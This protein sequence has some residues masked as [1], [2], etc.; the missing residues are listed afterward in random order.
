MESNDNRIFLNKLYLDPIE[1]INTTKL[2]PKGYKIKGDNSKQEEKIEIMR[3]LPNL[4]TNQSLTQLPQ[5]QRQ[6]NQLMGSVIVQNWETA[7]NIPED[8]G[9]LI[10]FPVLIDRKKYRYKDVDTEEDQFN[11]PEDRKS[12]FSKLAIKNKGEMLLKPNKQLEHIT[13]TSQNYV[14]SQSTA[15][16][17]LTS[18]QTEG[19]QIRA[20]ASQ[21]NAIRLRSKEGQEK[22]ALSLAIT[23]PPINLKS[24]KKLKLIDFTTFNKHLYLRDN[25][26]LYAKRV[27]GPVDFVLCTYQD[28]NPK[29][30]VSNHMSQSISGKKYLAPIGKKKKVIDYITISKNTVIHYQK[31]IPSVYSIQEWIDNYDKYKQLMKI[32][33]FKNFRNAKLFDLWR[34]FYKKTKRQYYTEKLKKKFFFID[35]H[36]LQGILETRNLLKGMKVVNIFD[37]QQSS[38]LLLNQFNELH[39]LNLVAIDKKI[40]LFRNKVKRILDTSCKESYKEYKTQKKITLDDDNNVGGGGNDKD[41]NKKDQPSNNIQNFIKDSIPYAQDATRKTHYKKLL[42]YI[43]VMDYVFNETK[44]D[45]INYSLEQLDKKFKRLYECYVNKW[46]DPPMLVTKIL[47]MGDKIYYNPS[48]RLMSES[49]FDN[50]IQETIYC[51][52][53]KKNFIDPQEFPR[54][55]S[56]FEEVFEIS[57]DQNSN[58]NNRIKETE[59]ITDKFESIKKNF[60]LCHVELNK[61]VEVL[62]PILDNYLKNSKINFKELEQTATP[63]QLKELLA[64]FHE[65]EKVIKQLKPVKAVGIFEFQLDDLLELV[66]DAPK[67]W[68]EKIR[69]VIPNVLITKVKKTIERLS[70]HLTDLSVNP[71]DIES[72]IKLKKAVE[73]CNKEKQL[74]EEVTNDIIDLQNIID[75]GKEIK[76]NDYDNK[77][78]IEL[79]DLNV[80]YDR[81]LDSTSYFI[82]NNIQQ[83]RLDLKNEIAKFD[84]QIKSMMSELNNDTL[85]TYNEDTFNALDFLEENSLKIKK[86]LVMKDKYQQQ[87]ED[88]ELDETLKSNFENLDNLV[89]EQELKVNLWNSVKEF[90]DQSTHWDSEQ[91]LQIN[92]E[93]MKNSI[94]H[95][96]DLCQVAL[97]DLDIPQVPMELKKKVEVYEQIVPILEAIQNV[98]IR[99]V[100]H[101]LTLLSELLRTE[102]KL[103]DPGFTCDRIKHL[104]EIFTRIPDIQELNNRANEE[105]RLKDIV[106]QTSDSF[107]NRKIPTKLTKKEIDKEFEF[108][109]ENLRMLNKIYLNKYFLFI[110]KDLDK[111]TDDLMKYQKF[112]THYVYFQ[113]YV[114]KSEAILEFNEFAKENPAEH[115]RLMSENLKKNFYKN[116]ADYRVIQKF[117]DHVYEKQIGLINSIIQSY[118]QNYKAIFNFFNKKRLETPRF[119]LLSNDDINNIFKE[120]ESNEIKQKMLYKIYR[121]I[122]YVNVDENPENTISLTTTDNEEFKVVLTK[123]SRTLQDLIEFLDVFLIKKLKDNF[124]TFKREYESSLK[125]KNPDDKK[126][127]DVIKDLITNKENLAQGIF[128]CIY[129]LTIDSIEKSLFVADEAFDKLFDLY[130]EIKDEK[131]VFFM[132]LI[133]EKDTTKVQK[134]VLFNLI[135]L[136]N[137]SKVIIENLIR[138]DVTTNN[139]FTF[140]K[141]INP[142]IENDSFTLHFIQNTFEYGF[143]YVGL[144]DNFLIMPE[145]ER[146]YIA[147]ANCIINQRPFTMYG[148]QD[149]GKKEILKI[150]ANLCGKK[151]NYINTTKNFSFTSF[152]NFF[153]G[154]IKQGC[155]LCIDETQNIKYEILETLALRIAEFYRILQSG[156]EF[157]LENGDKVTANVNQFSIFFYRELPYL[158]PFSDKSIPKVIKNYYRHMSMPKFDYYFYLNQSL[159]NLSIEKNEERTN[160][161]FY[162]LKYLQSKV[163][164]FKNTSLKMYFISKIIDDLNNK[165]S[166]LKENNAN[167][168]LY[169]RNLLMSLLEDIIDQKEKE[170]YRKFLNEVFLM[171]DYEEETKNYNDDP[172][173]NDCI[174]KVLSSMKINSQNYEKQI[175]FLYTSLL[176]FNSFILVGPP[177]SGKTNLIGLVVNISKQLFDIDKT[178][179]NKILNVKIY[180]KSQTSDDLFSENKVE[181]AY[182]PNNNFFYNMLSLFDSENEDMLM[183]LNEHYTKLLGFQ[184]PEVDEE[185]TPEK[186]KSLNEKEEDNDEDNIAILNQK[187]EEDNTTRT[188][189]MIILDGQIDDSWIEY[190]NNLYD[191]DNFLSLANGDVLN[192]NEGYKFV[193]ETASLRYAHPSFLTKQIIIPCSYETYG[194]ETILYTWI[195]SNPKVTENSVLKNYIRGLFENYFPRIN[196]FVVNNRMKSI[197]LGPNYI[198]KTLINIFDSI[199]PMFNFEDVKIGRR[200]FGVVPKIEIIKKCTLSIFIFS[201]AWTMNLLSNFV[202]KTKIE[203]LI[204]DIF[205]A[206]DLKGPIFDYYIDLDTNDFELWANLLKNEEYQLNLPS[207]DVPFYY[208]SIFIHTNETIPYTWLCEKFIDMNLPFYFNGKNTSGK[209]FLVDNVLDKKSEE[210]LDILKIKVVS[211]YYTTGNDVT[212]FIFS[213][214]NTIKRDLFGDK[215]QKEALLYIDDLNMNRHKDEYGT[216]NLFEYLREL[217]ENK[218][219]YDSK[220]NEIRYIK[221]FNMCC[222]GN[223]TAYPNE[224]EFN[225]FLSKYLLMTFVT[226]DDYYLN[227]FKPSLEFHFRQFI[228]NTSG[229]TATQYLQASLKLNNLLR[230]SIQQEPKKLH[231]QINI[232]DMVKVVQSFHDFKFRGTSDYPEYLK[233]IFFYES[234]V[235]YESKFNKKSDIDIFKEKICEAY[236]SVFKQDKVS[237]E[238][239]FNEQWDNGESYAF[240]RNYESFIKEVVETDTIN[241][242]PVSTEEKKEE[243]KDQ[244]EYH[245]FLDKKINLANYIKSKINVFY[246]GKDIKDRAYIKITDENI[247]IVIKMLRFFENK[248]PNLIMLGKE[249]IGKKPLFELSAFI[250]G[251]EIIE[252]D[253]S[254]TGDTTKTKDQFIHSTIV[255]FLVNATHKNKKTVMYVPPNIKANYIYE[256]INKMMDYREIM[257][258]FIFINED[259]YDE[260]SEEDAYNRLLSNISFCIEIIP[261]SQNYFKLFIDYPTIIKNASIINLHSWKNSDM[262]SFVDTASQEVEMDQEFKSNLS[263]LL[264]EIYDYT[265][266]IYDKFYKKTNIELFLCQKQFSTVCEFYMSKYTEYKNILLEKQKKYNEGLEIIDK[267]KTVIDSTNK[268]IEESSPLR[269]ELDKNIEETRKLINDKTREK[270]SWVAKKQQEDKVIEGLN[271][272]K[273]E[274]QNNLDSILQPFK[275]AIN[276][277]SYILN[278]IGQPDVMEIKNTWDSLNFGKYL[279]QKVYEIL[280]D[281]NNEWDTIKKSLD[282][283]VFKNFIGLSPLKNKE[284]LLPVVKE[285]TSNPDF[286]A[287]DKYQKPYKVCGTLCD[288]FNVCNNY[289]NELDNQKKLL[290]EIEALNVEIQGHT[291]TTKEY[292]QQ[293]TAIDNEVTEIEKKL[294]DLDTKKSNSHNHLLKLQALRDCFNGFID[295]ANQ[296]LHIW[297]SNK[298]NLD[299]ILKNF[300]FYLM[301]I[302]CYLF[303]A[304]PLSNNYRKEYKSFLYSLSKKLNLKD[305][306]EF[307]IYT[308]FIEL[309]DSSNKDN[310]FC[311]SIG[312]YSG[313]LADNFTMMYIMKDKIPYL[314]DSNRMSPDIIAT[315]LEMKTPKGIV[316]TNYNDANQPGEMFDKIENS[317]KN[318][319]I[320]FI[321][322]CEENIYDIM[323]NL[324]NEKFTYN[325]EKGKNCYLIKNKKMERHEKFKLYLIKS[326]PTSKIPKKAF[327]NCYVINFTCPAEVISMSIYDSLCKEQNLNSSQQ[328]SKVNNVINKDSFKLLE[329]EKKLLAYNKQFDFSGNLDKLEHNQSVLD[330]YTIES[331]THTTITKQINNNKK[332]IEI[333]DVELNKFKI[334]SNVAS[335]IY[336]LL[337]KFFYYDNFYV[338]PLEFMNDL[339]KEFYRINYGIYSKEIT[340]KIYQENK[341]KDDEENEED[342]EEKEEE[343]A[344]PQPVE[345][346]QNNNNGAPNENAD[347]EMEEREQQK[348]LE[349]E[350]K[351]QKELEEIYPC[352]KEDDSFELVIFIYNKISQIY[353]V[354]KRRHLLLILLFYGLKFKDEIPGNCKHII[355]NI[356]RIYFQNVLDHPDHLVKSPVSCIDD[357]T[358]NALKQINDCS[359]Y[360]FSIII[361]HIESHPQEWETFLDSEEALIERNFE[362]LD[363]ELASTINP[364]NKFLFFS[365]VKNNLSDSIINT[366]LKDIIKSQEVSY[367]DEGGETKYKK[368]S[369]DYIKNIEDL[370]FENFSTTKK[371]I[372]IFDNGNGEILYFHEIQDFYMPKLKEIIAEKNAKS[373][374]P[375]NETVSLK[376]IIP[377]KLEFTNAEL[378]TIHAAMKNG[379]VIFIRNCYMIKDS[380]IKLMEEIKDESTVLNEYFK[381]ILLVNNKNL[382]PYYL[383]KNCNIINR[384]LLVL[385]E[386]K[387][388]LIDLISSTPVNLFNRFMNCEF[389]NSSAYF[390]KK[391]YIY[392][393]MVNAVLIQYSNI[394]SKMYKIPI[395]FQRK[396]Y[397]SSLAYLYKYMTTISEDKQKELSNPDNFYGFTYE[398]LIKIV[399]DVFISARMITKE[400]FE[401]M[402]EF[403][404]H[405]Y[406]NSFFLKED[407]LFAYDEFVLQ[408]IDEKKYAINDE[409]VNIGEEVEQKSNNNLSGTLS[410]KQLLPGNTGA[411]YLIPKSALIE[412]FEKIPNETYYCLMY[413]ISN[414][415]LEEKRSIY[416]QQF[417]KIISIN[418][419]VNSNTNDKNIDNKLSK[420]DIKVVSDILK[421]L[422]QNL[423][424][425][426]NTTEANQ[427]L[428]KI[429]KYNELFN[430]LD[431]CL[432]KEIDSFNDYINKIEEDI[433]SLLSVLKGDMV[434]IE[435]YYE[436]IKSLNRKAIPKEW[437]LSKYS[438]KEVDTKEWTKK[439]K[440]I[441]DFLNNWILEGYS[442]IY[443][444]SLLFNEKLFMTLLPMYFQKKLGE[445]KISSDKIKLHFKLTKYEK[446][447]DV[448]EEVMYEYKKSN[449]DND[450]IFIK[451]LKLKGFESHKE[452]D[453]ELKTFKENEESKDE[454]LPIVVITY[455]VE[456]YQYETMNQKEEESEE[457]EDEDE[458]EIQ[459]NEEVKEENKNENPQQSGN[460]PKDDEENI[461]KNE[462]NNDNNNIS[463]EGNNEENNNIEINNNVNEENNNTNEDNNNENNIYEDNNNENNTNE[464]N[465]NENNTNEENNYGNNTN[466][467]NN[468]GNNINEENNYGNNTNE[469][470]NYGNNIN[471]YNNYGNNTNE[472]NNYGNNVNEENNNENE[473]KKENEDNK[474]ND[475]K[476][477]EKENN[478]EEQKQENKENNNEE[479]NQENNNEEQNQENEENTENNNEEQKQENEENKENNNE[480]QKVEEN[481]IDNIDN[482]NENDTKE[483]NNEEKNEQEQIE[484]VKEQ[485]NEQEKKEEEAKEIQT[486]EIK[487]ETEVKEDKNKKEEETK[488]EEA[489]KEEE[490]MAEEPKKEEEKKE[491]KKEIANNEEGEKRIV[492]EETHIQSKKMAFIETMSNMNRTRQL[493]KDGNE[494]TVKIRT[495]VKYFKKHCRIEVPF[496]EEQDPNCYNINEPYGYIELRFDCDKDKQEEYFKNKQLAIELDK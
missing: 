185:L 25:D 420:I 182:R 194:W 32:S 274:L 310:E 122:K 192:C 285:V 419:V 366:I 214:L 409:L 311:S 221:K 267:V 156:G 230:N 463:N 143:E 393:T 443:D 159:I 34:R 33:L 234:S 215:N 66:S 494:T 469:E 466:E 69:K 262:Q 116:L 275:D 474:N 133:K 62:R 168:D 462:E 219:I 284:K 479:Q 332:R 59:T 56:C 381:L 453:R 251:I 216:S 277:A 198:M 209:S 13:I 325:A 94:K 123:S 399:S 257:N 254:F 68:L 199:L 5:S 436:M 164:T 127:K 480:E 63:T 380:L 346:A 187:Q 89:Y 496:I 51:V 416:I 435:K 302:S 158:S 196:E 26:F 57:V 91:V 270:K 327:T 31:G 433:N 458:E 490:A 223:L 342:E 334:I 357:R 44:F 77:F 95:W 434:M 88:L 411:K 447:I 22:E 341:K 452:E 283:K 23:E 294:G 377:T 278:K 102:V 139:D 304:A 106:Q 280:G 20:S 460:G 180:S 495:K 239:I 263:D 316:Q 412:E 397:F 448:T 83:F 9:E 171:K 210:D 352:F 414:K 340:K 167:I 178:K 160:K 152:S 375:V 27:G 165:I 425:L 369:L 450:F 492:V 224:D 228:P 84:G 212:D 80:K 358:W 288:Y 335:K 475:Q 50:F 445:E 440:K 252:I 42:R 134:R 384:D 147:F 307:N 107:Y 118:E 104:P 313:F 410:N 426:L 455:S 441:Y 174:S 374:S 188:L 486:K 181:R 350:L 38:P 349:K 21:L 314:I 415:M 155:W 347:A 329:I 111:L 279:L 237:V 16:P 407:F 87:E 74:H 131:T 55:M 40:D 225:R 29:S 281:N 402:N 488:T 92:L 355:Y 213:N 333:F 354:N 36:L 461:D 175:K 14:T 489:K 351:R 242:N 142:K 37:L 417:F 206:D 482:K 431:E 249:L 48:I 43:R 148:I 367:I 361:D 8:I 53:Y 202:I 330:K 368:Y 373:E 112:L 305:I 153:Y 157:E 136:M 273:K 481:N 238:L 258:N 172:V 176:N 403:L 117:L 126:P 193:F 130:N 265:Q 183:K 240:T 428:F 99:E 140:V 170:E 339:V 4:H 58:L 406:E 459:M 401:N 71:T 28:I 317:M 493:S 222:C 264:I 371:P 271:K 360:I 150:F 321:K 336:K 328:R 207:K 250:S 75:T 303:Y 260:I 54:Y 364:F 287:G 177:L 125:A 208:G 376:E 232:K 85:N 233:K 173:I 218:Y 457:E 119:Y 423:P 10:H 272:K 17:Q 109:E 422:K 324:I 467:E 129:Y 299:I 231:S 477:E 217:V 76:I 390:M 322:Q 449:N 476:D 456:D 282:L 253:N 389:N 1:S 100:P 226:S 439:L 72:F 204:A 197:T 392:F 96:L 205:K 471:E 255:P 438:T 386:M 391:L 468:Y 432:Q 487:N 323:E 483:Q 246:R 362:V 146:M 82:D 70:S 464:N 413:G 309:L 30:K 73:A 437:S 395:G 52:I 78:I 446:P 3:S 115:K 385:T 24:E 103:D 454:S 220:N 312:H 60:E 138:D 286:S 348:I 430:P 244:Q 135:S 356:D 388:F 64:E 394:K 97:V 491:E 424:D 256:T 345:E 243:N 291:K 2:K 398:S 189:K 35:H 154:N 90:K 363:E 268:E 211:S 169:L 344:Q 365:I 478:N 331:N 49:V 289:Y 186:L 108:V 266:K 306:K 427:V 290:D 166:D 121:W 442:N 343:E 93:Q 11:L 101:L 229:I 298:E 248:N 378:D 370:F 484:Q 141:I 387:E 418:N 61:E 144:Q 421:D 128:N 145:S 162:I 472:D 300:D 372:M 429:N 161:I 326:K 465:N 473:E 276:K 47:C 359:S 383:Y 67:Q 98:N 315:F 203:K 195:E 124:K 79:K 318:G 261:K 308:I 485:Q 18:E 319:T 149:S 297:K 110:K 179:Y 45:T 86:C 405:M 451:G 337:M 39:K 353:D 269:Q 408:N 46:V 338:I 247:E 245:V 191:K 132:N 113:K 301:V 19:N 81:K 259:E 379:G 120:R 241:I 293:A 137:Y 184:E 292:I 320:L 396:D 65:K 15:L 227:I 6:Q 295:V 382:L 200:N 404:L 114:Q 163:S 151:I 296:K 190:I 444:L 201:C 235:V 236:N 470:N 12:K 400:E 105:K 7:K 41:D